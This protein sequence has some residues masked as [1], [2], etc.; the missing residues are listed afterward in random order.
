MSAVSQSLLCHFIETSGMIPEIATSGASDWH[1]L[2]RQLRRTMAEALVEYCTSE[3]A[4][5]WALPTNES[6]T[7]RRCS[8]KAEAEPAIRWDTA[9]PDLTHE[10]HVPALLRRGKSASHSRVCAIHLCRRLLLSGAKQ[11]ARLTQGGKA[12]SILSAAFAFAFVT[13]LS[14]ALAA[15]SS[16]CASEVDVICTEQGPVRGV[17]EGETLAFKG[18]PYAK[19]PIG[20]LRWKPPEPPVHWDGIRDGSEF[21]T[22]SA[23]GRQ[24]SQGGG[25]L[26][27]PQHMAAA[28]EGRTA[29]SCNGL[30]YRGRQ[31]CAFRPRNLVL[32]GSRL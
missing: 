1:P 15:E 12:V 27:L 31:S 9:C 26:P 19:P 11:R 5:I 7:A 22:M 32:R 3:F 14:A 6:A 13:S 30:A 24:R 2:L 18:I 17:P 21:G 20:T 10:K 25:R 8:R 28:R 23:T 4:A 16:N 29:P